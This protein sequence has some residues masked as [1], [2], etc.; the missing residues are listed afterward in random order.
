MLSQWQEMKEQTFITVGRYIIVHVLYC[1]VSIVHG[2]VH[3]LPLDSKSTSQDCRPCDREYSVE[4]VIIGKSIDGKLHYLIKWQ[5]FPS[6]CNTG[7]N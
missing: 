3:V 5:K 6:K 1:S 7:T 4:K 2:H